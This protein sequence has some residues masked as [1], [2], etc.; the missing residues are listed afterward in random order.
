MVAL[1]L[2][3]LDELLLLLLL[4][5]LLAGAAGGCGWLNLCSHWL[6]AHEG[7][8][9]WWRAVLMCV[10]SFSKLSWVEDTVLALWARVLYTLCLAVMW[11]LL[12]QWRYWSV[13]VGFL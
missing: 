9:Q 3:L 12:S 8:W 10:S 5:L 11:Q 6:R 13:C 7:N 2:L 1:Y 4:L